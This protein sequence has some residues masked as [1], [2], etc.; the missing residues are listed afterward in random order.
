MFASL[1]RPHCCVSAPQNIYNPKSGCGSRQEAVGGRAVYPCDI[2]AD[3]VRAGARGGERGA[4]GCGARGGRVTGYGAGPEGS[5]AV[6]TAC[7]YA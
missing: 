2:V 1:N 7:L 4:A 3:G 5:P 6:G